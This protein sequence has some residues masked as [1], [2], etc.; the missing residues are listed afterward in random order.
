MRY[1]EVFHRRPTHTGVI[2]Q[3]VWSAHARPPAEG[4]PAH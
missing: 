3:E 2:N 4:Q 1:H